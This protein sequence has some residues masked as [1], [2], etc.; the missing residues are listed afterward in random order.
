MIFTIKNITNK[1]QFVLLL[2]NHSHF[3]SILE[4]PNLT[5]TQALSISKTLPISFDISKC[6][7]QYWISLLSEVAEFSIS[8]SEYEIDIELEEVKFKEAQDWYQ[9]LSREDKDKVNLLIRGSHPT[10]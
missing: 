7:Q 3:R 4:M 8:K 2:K 1:K 9:T 10:A 6:D 5:L